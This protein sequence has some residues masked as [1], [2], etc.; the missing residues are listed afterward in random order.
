MP[1]ILLG[2]LVLVWGTAVVV[3]GLSGHSGGGSY[4]TGQFFA[5]LIAVV[6]IGAGVVAVRSGFRERH[7]R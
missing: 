4:A 5:W 7:H 3:Q 6:L 2:T 1:R